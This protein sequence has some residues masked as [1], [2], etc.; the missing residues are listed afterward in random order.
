MFHIVVEHMLIF[1]IERQPNINN[2]IINIDLKPLKNFKTENIS[3]A[4]NFIEI[5]KDKELDRMIKCTKADET[6]CSAEDLKNG[7][8][9]QAK[10]GINY[11]LV[12]QN[13]ISIKQSHQHLVVI[14]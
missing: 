6:K 1:K 3:K 11:E 13:I 2:D 10:D 8:T 9:I 12:D 14:L 7:V 5:D 4:N